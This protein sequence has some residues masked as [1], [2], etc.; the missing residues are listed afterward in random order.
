MSMWTKKTKSAPGVT[1]G[2]KT[3][4]IP[5]GG[6]DA[7]G[8]GFD[9]KKIVQAQTQALLAKSP[10]D[11]GDNNSPG[12]SPGLV[13]TGFQW[14][15]LPKQKAVTVKTKHPRLVIGP[16]QPGSTFPRAVTQG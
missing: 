13:G 7:P 14:H 11:Q 1:V 12:L 9:P 5:V 6:R 3:P 16:T 2:G 4:P 10:T 8:H 15:K